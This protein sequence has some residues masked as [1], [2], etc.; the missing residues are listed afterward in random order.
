MKT[1]AKKGLYGKYYVCKADQKT[2]LPEDD[3][4]LDLIGIGNVFVLR[5]DKDPHAIAALKAYAA[6]CAEENPRL[7]GDLL[8]LVAEHEGHDDEFEVVD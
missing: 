4:R 3:A 2:G 6:S 8:H 7:A 5:Y 1:E